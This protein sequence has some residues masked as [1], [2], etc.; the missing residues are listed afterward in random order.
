MPA[1]TRMHRILA[2][3]RPRRNAV[4]SG[5]F[6]CA[7][8]AAAPFAGAPAV[9]L[10]PKPRPAQAD[11]SIQVATAIAI[12]LDRGRGPVVSL[13]PR[14]RPD[15]LVIASRPPQKKFRRKGSV[16]GVRAIRGATIEQFSDSSSGCGIRNPVRIT[17]VAGVGLSTPAIVD[18]ETAKALHRWVVKAAEPA[19][20]RRG[21]GLS[22]LRVAASYACRTRNNRK[23]AKL[24]EHAKGH[25]IDISGFRLE[26][27]TQVT[28]LKGWNSV[29]YGSVL[30]KLHKSACGTFGT[31]L[32]PRSDAHHRDHFHF[33]TARYRKGAY[34][35]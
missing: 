30:K 3:A 8:T 9:S 34:C 32:G 12:D 31:V 22:E 13:I 28:V 26:N 17:S 35:R 7:A 16:C 27:G 19:L 23:G 33:D 21:G 11:I 10:I 15:N 20:R 1:K 18:C 5:L 6:L 24:S 4:L 29:R 14:A 2:V 25:A